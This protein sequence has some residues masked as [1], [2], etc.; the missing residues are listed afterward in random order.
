M[1]VNQQM[2]GKVPQVT[3]NTD[4]KNNESYHIEEYK[5]SSYPVNAFYPEKSNSSYL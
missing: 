5:D 4:V 3:Q 1:F 2:S